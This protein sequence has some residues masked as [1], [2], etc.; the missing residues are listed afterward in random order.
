MSVTT[1]TTNPVTVVLPKEGNV[2]VS[3]YGSLRR[4]M[5]NFRVNANGGG[6]YF[7]TGES[8]KNINLYRYGGAYFPSISLTHDSHGVPVVLDVFEVPMEGLTGAYDC[9]EGYNPRN[10]QAGFYNRSEIEVVLDNGDRL[11]AWVYHIDEE[12]PEAV[13]SGDWCTFND[14]SYYEQFKEAATEA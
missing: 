5:Q 14:P 12:Q 8:A 2:F 1:E 11:T 4:G 10:P 7:G 6:V 9:L 13:L 3:T